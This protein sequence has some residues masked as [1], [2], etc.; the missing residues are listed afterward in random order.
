[1]EYKSEA[2]PARA[3]AKS[4]S[5][6]ANTYGG[7]LFVGVREESKDNAVAGSFPASLHLTSTHC[8]SAF[9]IRLQST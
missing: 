8:Y 3:L 6:F 1:M 2:V 4:L 7:W 5:A 9:D